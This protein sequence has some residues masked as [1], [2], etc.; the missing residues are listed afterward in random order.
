MR[1]AATI[2]LS[3]I[4]SVIP[5]FAATDNRS[6]ENDKIKKQYIYEWTDPQGGVHIT[7][8]FG[9]V[10]VPYREKARKVEMPKGQEVGPEQRMTGGAGATSEGAENAQKAVWRQ[11]LR[12]W[13]KRLADAKNRYNYL[14]LKRQE[15]LERWGPASGH[16]EGRIEAENLE[17]EMKSVQKDIDEARN[18]IETIIPEEARRAGIPPGWLR[19]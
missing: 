14:K 4:V 9:D 2:V 16:L 18:M 12:E 6:T 5:A 19:E 1:I 11:R 7:D 15:A 17:E 13:K 10:P 3:L 8:D